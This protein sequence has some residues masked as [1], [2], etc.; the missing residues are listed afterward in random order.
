M[1][2]S[3]K[4][5]DLIEINFTQPTLT[6]DGYK[7]VAYAYVSKLD[8][9]LGGNAIGFDAKYLNPM[10]TEICTFGYTPSEYWRVIS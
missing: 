8:V 5:G 4:I 9:K 10:L 6:P 1:E 3:V 7:K 2:R